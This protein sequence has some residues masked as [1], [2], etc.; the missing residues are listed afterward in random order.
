MG[1]VTGLPASSCCIQ[2]M[3]SEA[4][5]YGKNVPSKEKTLNGTLEALMSQRNGGVE[6]IAD[7]KEAPGSTSNRKYRLK[8]TTKECKVGDNVAATECNLGTI[9]TDAP[10]YKEAEI[11]ITGVYKFPI[12]LDEADY[13]SICESPAQGYTDILANKIDAAVTGYNNAVATQ[14]ALTMGDYPSGDNSLTI[15]QSL[16]P[17]NSQKMFN[18]QMLAHLNQHYRKMKI[19]DKPMVVAGSVGNFGFAMETRA[20]ATA[21]QNGINLAGGDVSGIYL[22]DSL[23]D[24]AV[25]PT[26]SEHLLSWAPGTIKLVEYFANVGDYRYV[27]TASVNGQERAIKEQSVV[28]LGGHTWDLLME[29]VC[30]VWTYVLQKRF[31]VVGIPANAFATTC[32]T[33]NYALHFLLDCGDM[34][35]ST[36]VIYSIP[37]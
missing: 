4:D 20:F 22:D 23:N 15:P 12:K 32:Q 9:A 26:G 2:L 5:F 27:Q 36:P 8:Y 19:A 34:S 3:K 35:C 33:G 16:Y 24:L 25:F 6:T 29:R 1:L 13:R 30:G 21:N 14:L 10:P 37:D 17:L 31:E 18:P 28:Q 7:G 11:E